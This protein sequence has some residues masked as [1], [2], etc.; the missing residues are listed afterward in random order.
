[1]HA[2]SPTIALIGAGRV[3]LNLLRHCMRREVAVSAV[4][5]PNPERLELI[6]QLLPASQ[7]TA[8]V[9][10]HF[11]EGTRYVVIAVPDRTIGEIAR[12]LS[13]MKCLPQG[14]VLFHCSGTL[15]SSVLAPLAHNGC[16]VGSVHPMQSFPYDALPDDA[17][18]G[19]GCGIE[20]DDAFWHAGREFAALMEW[21]P[22]R[23]DARKKAL[24]H[25]ANVFAGNFPTVLAA[26][27]ESLLR[28]A[29]IAAEDE[30]LTHLIP[31]MSAVVGRLA[32]SDPASSLT[33][34]AARGDQD[35]IRLHL[36]ELATLDPRFRE[37]YEA[38]TRAALE[39]LGK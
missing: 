28:E 17:L 2:P 3:G 18:R 4:V 23:I 16:I 7:V 36:E 6:R 20:G 9:P 38:L 14:L 26:L 11:P 5:E 10:S 21:R 12:Q 25:A 33:G 15:D 31:M 29:A 1:M 30:R 22:L 34:P 27:A 39:L 37:I 35:T 8:E 24:Y 13:T 32:D 19:I